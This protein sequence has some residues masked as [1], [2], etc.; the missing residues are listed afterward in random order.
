[1]NAPILIDIPALTIGAARALTDLSGE[2]WAAT[3]ETP[4]RNRATLRNDKTGMQLEVYQEANTRRVVVIL[5]AIKRT[6]GA[7]VLSWC[8]DRVMV[9]T[10]H[11][12]NLAATVNVILYDRLAKQE[13]E[14]PTK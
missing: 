14:R 6:L 9:P 7:H 8:R 3:Y 10:A 11:C 4:P 2:P 5:G 12:M 13:K 1:M